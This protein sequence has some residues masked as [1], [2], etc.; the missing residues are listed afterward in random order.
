MSVLSE[1]RIPDTRKDKYGIEN[2]SHFDTH[3]NTTRLLV[4][5]HF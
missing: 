2:S 1:T 3:E 4:K 5:V